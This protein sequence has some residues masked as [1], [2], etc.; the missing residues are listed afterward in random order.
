MRGFTTLEWRRH[1]GEAW[2]EGATVPYAFAYGRGQRLLEA[3]KR[4]GMPKAS[5]RLRNTYYENVR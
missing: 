5:V 3:L 2:N 1:D 4:G